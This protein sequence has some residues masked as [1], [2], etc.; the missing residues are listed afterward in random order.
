MLDQKNTINDF[1]KRV[2]SKILKFAS[3][4]MF[5]R[6]K[7]ETSACKFKRLHKHL[8]TIFHFRLCELVTRLLR[9]KRNKYIETLKQVCVD[10]G[11]KATEMG[12]G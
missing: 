10:K 11:R 3:F 1:F 6:L 9:I 8:L 2:I 7:F 12:K 5:H 4:T